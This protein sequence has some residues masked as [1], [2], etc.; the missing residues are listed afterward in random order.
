MTDAPDEPDAPDDREL[1]ARLRA[2]DP[3]AS[4]PSAD[5]HRVARLLEDT[6]R[7][8]TD[9]TETTR[10]RAAGGQRRD[11]RHRSP[12]TWLVAAAAVVLIAGAAFALIGRGTDPTGTPVAGAHTSQ[13]ITYLT[14][15]TAR[16]GARCPVVSAALLRG[17]G[18]A[19]DAEVRDIAGDRVTLVPKKFYAG[20]STDL[21]VV[22]ADR[23]DPA[24]LDG[25]VD[26]RA[27]ER[28][29]VSAND[30][31]VSVCGLSA[32]WSQRLADL[33]AEAFGS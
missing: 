33:Y 10:L 25:A 24:G 3:A 18:L 17:R 2:G 27:G 4:L 31:Q 15:P 7:E 30:G 13:S 29:L 5:P 8:S 14:L 23:S 22:R 6:M 26:F 19:V 9:I 11:L 32:P 20:R 21:L 1:L 16:A 28:Y 12:L